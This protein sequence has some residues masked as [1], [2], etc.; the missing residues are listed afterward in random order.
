MRIE[1]AKNNILNHI[2]T[3]RDQSPKKYDFSR[4][5]S[6]S[7]LSR[8]FSEEQRSIIDSSGQITGN[9]THDDYLLSIKKKL[10]IEASWAS[11]ALE[12]N[13][14]SLI[15]TE[16]LFERGMEMPGAR[17]EETIMLLNHKHAI[18]YIL[19]NINDINISR[20]DVMNIHALLSNGLM[21]D[22]SDV[23]SIRVKP[24][25]ISSS[26]YKPLDVLS[27][28]SEEF[29]ALLQLAGE[30]KDPID[31]S[32]FLLINIAY[33]QPFTDVNKR[34]SRMTANIPLLKAGLMPMSFYQMDRA[35]Y[36]KGILHY[37]ETG[38]F[39]RLAKEYAKCYK[40]SADRFKDLIENKPSPTEMRLRLKYRKD[41]ARCVFDIV[42]NG[43]DINDLPSTVDAVDVEFFTRYL[44]GVLDSLSPGN[45]LLYNLSDDD[46]IAW[47]N[48]QSPS[49]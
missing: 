49:I 33:L 32:F 48:I 13:T 3:T 30:I 22:P 21:K 10:L 15:D 12:G 4:I 26:T 9:I 11:S 6:F 39:R 29:D 31:Q 34:T 43:A 45:S 42:K 8:F 46:V 47:K 2:I 40:V 36:E 41:V 38:D 37:Y 35:G 16:E 23:G 1:N 28:I 5:I 14:Y 19:E 17:Q 27:M 44:S 20:R 18:E 7:D 24:V 25:G